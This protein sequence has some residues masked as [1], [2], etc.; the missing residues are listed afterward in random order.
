MALT[1]DTA[2][3]YESETPKRVF[4][5][6]GSWWK[7]ADGKRLMVVSGSFFSTVTDPAYYELLEKGKTMPLKVE[8]QSFD[9]QVR[10]KNLIRVWD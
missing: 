6:R 5:P 9:D 7:S 8:K 10:L 3:D 4:A 2:P 1:D